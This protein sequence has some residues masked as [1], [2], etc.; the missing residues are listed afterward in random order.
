M[1]AVL[2]AFAQLTT[3][4]TLAARLAV[5]V[6]VAL[7]RLP[8]SRPGLAASP[9]GRAAPAGPARAARSFPLAGAAT[10]RAAAAPMVAVGAGARWQSRT[11]APSTEGHS[12]CKAPARPAA[13][14]TEAVRRG[15]GTKTHER[16]WESGCMIRSIKL[17]N[18]VGA[19]DWRV[20][21]VV[22]PWGLWGCTR[23]WGCTRHIHT[24]L[25]LLETCVWQIDVVQ[26]SGQFGTTIEA[27][28]VGL[29]RVRQ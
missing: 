8:R 2:V 29:G 17:L 24:L 20:G 10:G 14:A 9:A 23:R 1:N 3:R 4:P 18:C 5:A 7:R 27:V 6:A 19:Y 15:A 28:L 26:L 22:M 25:E 13:P 21:A 16:A 12:S 11:L